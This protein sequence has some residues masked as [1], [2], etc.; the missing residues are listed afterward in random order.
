MVK[1]LFFWKWKNHFSLLGNLLRASE[2]W[3]FVSLPNDVKKGGGIC[4]QPAASKF[5]YATKYSK[6]TMFLRWFY[7]GEQSDAFRRKIQS[8]WPFLICWQ[9]ASCQILT[10]KK[11]FTWLKP[12][13]LRT[14]NI[15]SEYGFDA[16]FT[17]NQLC[18]VL[19]YTWKISFVSQNLSCWLLGKFF[20]GC[21]KRGGNETKNQSSDA[22]RVFGGIVLAIFLK[23][24]QFKIWARS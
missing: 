1:N 22:L 5:F 14:L 4:Q 23:R 24:S 12:M 9:T 13:S 2:L 11:N 3:F 18:S 20:G 19:K 6:T 15:S 10:Q 17:T 21:K 7:Y 16:Q 8:F